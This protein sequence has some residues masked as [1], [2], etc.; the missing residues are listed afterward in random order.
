MN[1]FIIVIAFLF[2]G[3]IGIILSNVG[4]Y[5]PQKPFKNWCYHHDEGLA[6]LGGTFFFCNLIAL[7]VMVACVINMPDYTRKIEN[8]YANTKALIESY[9]GNDYGNMVALTEKVI[10]LNDEIA[11]NKAYCE[12]PWR[13]PW[14]SRRIGDLEPIVYKVSFEK[15]NE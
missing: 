1:W 9:K 11:R 10:Y 7:A 5:N 2:V 4:D 13:G 6:V 8:E 12:S 15:P 14:S 3:I